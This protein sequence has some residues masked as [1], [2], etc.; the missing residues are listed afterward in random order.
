[1]CSLL[2]HRTNLTFFDALNNFDLVYFLLFLPVFTHLFTTLWQK[3]QPTLV[4]GFLFWHVPTALEPAF[5]GEV[6]RKPVHILAVERG[7]LAR[8]RQGVR[9][10]AIG[11]YPDVATAIARI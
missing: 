6:L 1:M 11:E 3:R 8:K 4:V 10:F 2:F 5:R 7:E 9:I